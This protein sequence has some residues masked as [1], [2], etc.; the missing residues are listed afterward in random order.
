MDQVRTS[1][2]SSL[3]LFLLALAAAVALALLVAAGLPGLASSVASNGW[4]N[5]PIASNGWQKSST[6]LASNGWQTTLAS[7]GWQ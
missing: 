4:Q 2:I 1:R 7:N 5:K 3:P 6:V